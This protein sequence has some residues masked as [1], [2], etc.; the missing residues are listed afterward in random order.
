MTDKTFEDCGRDV[1]DMYKGK[2]CCI[3]HQ[4]EV[5]EGI[6][7]AIENDTREFF[8]IKDI[9]QHCLDK[10]KVRDT[11]FKIF[12][13]EETLTDGIWKHKSELTIDD[14]KKLLTELGL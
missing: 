8:E 12:G 6:Q 13:I 9:Q 11:I 1:L 4:K 14:I 3:K 2:F 10:Q 5:E 7:K